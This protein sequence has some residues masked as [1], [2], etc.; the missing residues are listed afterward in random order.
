MHEHI[1]STKLPLCLS[2]LPAFVHGHVHVASL[3]N[4]QRS[5]KK[6][7]FYPPTRATKACPASSIHVS[8]TG[9]AVECPATQMKFVG[10]AWFLSGNGVYRLDSVGGIV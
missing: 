10:S 1:P 2:D 5:D 3:S 6:Q 9:L 8:C 4:A 7:A